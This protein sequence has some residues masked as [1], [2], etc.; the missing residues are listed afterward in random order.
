M[1]PAIERLSDLP[2]DQ[3]GPLIEESV[4]QGLRFLRRLADEWQAG[5]GA[6]TFYETLGFT[7]VADAEASTH[8]LDLRARTPNGN[9]GPRSPAGGAAGRADPN[10][11]SPARRL[12][13]I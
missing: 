7:R 5:T 10:S 4:S 13:L 3:L 6:A 8:L 9:R 2:L 1:R 12:R 11:T